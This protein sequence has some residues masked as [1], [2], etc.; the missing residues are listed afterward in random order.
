MTKPKLTQVQWK[1]DLAKCEYQATASTQN[2]DYSY[3]S[4]FGQSLDQAMRRNELIKLCLKAEGYTEQV[5][6]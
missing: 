1:K 5:Q 6:K 3:S 4:G 2:V